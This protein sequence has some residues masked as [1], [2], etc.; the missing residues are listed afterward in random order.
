MLVK[1]QSC[2]LFYLIIYFN[3]MSWTQM[4]SISIIWRPRDQPTNQLTCIIYRYR[5][6]GQSKEHQQN[7]NKTDEPR[8]DTDPPTT[9]NHR[10]TRESTARTIAHRNWESNKSLFK[11]S[12]RLFVAT[13]RG[14]RILSET[15]S[16]RFQR[17]VQT[18]RLFVSGQQQTMQ[19]TGA[20]IRSEK[21]LLHEQL[22]WA[23]PSV[24][25]D[26]NA[27]HHRQI[28]ECRH[29]WNGT[30]RIDASCEHGET[31]DGVNRCVRVQWFGRKWYWH[32]E[33]VC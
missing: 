24:T 26:E 21:G 6:H 1:I 18:M 23:Q 7:P 10:R 2:L 30:E 16:A 15:H 12:V 31:F 29:K 13:H 22:L 14:L 9:K 20:E 25:V 17:T 33:T 5:N 8:T 3:L 27:K 4:T 19:S 11:H 32:N 28:Q